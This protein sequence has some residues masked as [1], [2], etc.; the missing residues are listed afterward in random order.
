MSIKLVEIKWLKFA[1]GT[2]FRSHLLFHRILKRI[3][4]EVQYIYAHVL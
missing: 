1:E 2:R 4:V 3:A